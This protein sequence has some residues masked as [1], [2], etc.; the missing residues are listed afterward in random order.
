MAADAGNLMPPAI[1]GGLAME[2]T[3]GV[4]FKTNIPQDTIK[5]LLNATDIENSRFDIGQFE[6]YYGQD[7]IS[8]CALFSE[9]GG[10]LSI[11]AIQM[12]HPFKGY[13]YIA[14]IQTLKK[15]YGLP[16]L[17]HIVDEFGKVWLMANTATEDTLVDYYR[18]TGLFQ[19]IYI[20][21]SVWECPAY[22]FCT[23]GCD[24]DKLEGYCYAF[25]AND[26]GNEDEEVQEFNE[27]S[28]K[29]E[30]SIDYPVS[31]GLCPEIWD[32]VEEGKFKIKP[33]IKQRALE[34]VDKLLAKYH[35]EA[36]GVNVVGSICS[37]QYTDDGDVDIHIQVDLPED[38][39]EK[40]N[41]LRKKTQ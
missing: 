9:D 8:W 30:S 11:A 14:E 4:V 28:V 2:T 40:L 41:N 32:E 12:N 5:D 35:V 39:A 15:G 3:E 10:C 19:E 6:K 16:L 34:L 37:N 27:S 20:E 21:D 29:K 26:D 13:V 18:D 31:E 22:F 17:K 38:V 25:Y 36:K 33:E 7:N 23:D 1:H 24:Y